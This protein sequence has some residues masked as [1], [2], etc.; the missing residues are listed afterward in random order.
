MK[1][2]LGR[3][4]L[5]ASVIAALLGL[6]SIW[7]LRPNERMTNAMLAS[8]PSLSRGDAWEHIPE[9]TAAFIR[10]NHPICLVSPR[11]VMEQNQSAMIR[12]W[13]A[14]ERI[15]R[16]SLIAVLWAGFSVTCLTH[17]LKRDCNA[18]RPKA[19]GNP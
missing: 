18:L 11:W 7:E 13:I 15:A 10:Q 12:Q 8:N 1:A 9:N 19:E 3:Q 4:L 6:V 17:E 2:V 16:L 5:W 14:S